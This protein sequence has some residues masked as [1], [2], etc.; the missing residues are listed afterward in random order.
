MENIL[1]VLKIVFNLDPLIKVAFLFTV[2]CRFRYI[3]EQGFL[4]RKSIKWSSTFFFKFFV[5]CFFI[6]HFG[7]F[8]LIHINCIIQDKDNELCMCNYQY[9]PTFL[10]ND[11]IYKYILI[12][13]YL[14]D[15]FS[16][17]IS[18][19][20]LYYEYIRN[21]P[22]SW[23]SLRLFW[24]VNGLYEIAKTFSLI[25][26]SSINMVSI[27]VIYIFQSFLSFILLCLSL[28]FPYDYQTTDESF[29]S[30]LLQES[31]NTEYEAID[32]KS[33][34]SKSV[35]YNI[36][37]K[38]EEAEIDSNDSI[39][40]AEK[41][42]LLILNFSLNIMSNNKENNDK[43]SSKR[44]IESI[45]DFNERIEKTFR[46]IAKKHKKK[47]N[48][49]GYVYT[50]VNQVYTISLIIKNKKMK[51]SN[52]VMSSE[53]QV[54][55][56]EKYKTLETIYSKLC[57][58]NA[59][60]FLE[61]LKFLK[62]NNKMIIDSLLQQMEIFNNQLSTN[63]SSS[64][65]KEKELDH[66]VDAIN[67]LEPMQTNIYGL[68]NYFEDNRKL[69]FR[70]IN[71]IISN[72]E[73][74]SVKANIYDNIGGTL[75]CSLTMNKETF[76]FSITLRQIEEY[77]NKEKESNKEDGILS[78]INTLIQDKQNILN[79]IKGLEIRLT[80]LI[81]DI[82]YYNENLFDLFPIDVIMKV[83]KSQL[84]S[85]L[86]ISFFDKSKSPILYDDEEEDEIIITTM[87][88]KEKDFRNYQFDCEIE[89]IYNTKTDIIIIVKLK[90]ICK[91]KQ[92][93]VWKVE[94]SLMELFHLLNDIMNNPQ[95][96][97]YY[98][99]LENSLSTLIEQI[100]SLF[101][102]YN[103]V[104]SKNKNSLHLL[105]T[106][107]DFKNKIKVFNDKS[108]MLPIERSEI[109]SL[110]E[111]SLKILLQDE[112][113]YIFYSSSFRSLINISFINKQ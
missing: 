81:N 70:Y 82:L 102:E 108:H 63:A 38:V 54:S 40:E 57:S 46:E 20:L 90:A 47:D 89:Q 25:Y 55:Y 92:F 74:I 83:Q 14:L 99:V 43:Y 31:N 72:E 56:K 39:N 110:L 32:G 109:F 22:Q 1:N 101:K 94:I 24:C 75:Q 64:S 65:H 105:N 111:E 36:E 26:S 13:Y 79:N 23:T 8:T 85:E 93:F 66:L 104:L 52:N 4:S 69:I 48:N 73:Y 9:S 98:K 78:Q 113:R 16:W 76:S 86:F 12:A 62:Y 19:V 59:Q 45:I 11:N 33:N 88:K 87:K 30:N 61:F 60:F 10:S 27:M 80:K 28:F 67:L 17:F 96:K 35:R 53:T 44:S 95:V 97:Q 71:E 58:L 106:S 50:L 2:L 6:F 77:I 3:K 103:I 7:S 37:I 68:S 112:N 34:A 107:N 51:C 91:T 29:L 84:K 5:N 21:I 100:A 49:I 18:T 15:S 41:K 42:A